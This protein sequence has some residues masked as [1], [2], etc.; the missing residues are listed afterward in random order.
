MLGGQPY[1]VKAQ[2]RDLRYNSGNL[3]PNCIIRHMLTKWTNYPQG[4]Y[5]WGVTIVLKEIRYNEVCVFRIGRIHV[6]DAIYFYYLL[7]FVIHIP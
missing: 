3:Y 2:V 1:T 5:G 6:Y 4:I 7:L